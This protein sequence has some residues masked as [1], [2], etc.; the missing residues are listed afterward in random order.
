VASTS[1]CQKPNA[2]LETIIALLTP[3]F[4]TGTTD[5]FDA[6]SAVIETLAAYATRTRGELLRAAQIIAL[7]MTTLDVLAEAKT[8]EMSQS[9]R[10]RY[11]GCANSLNRCASNTE[12]ALERRLACD[13]PSTAEPMPEPASD[14]TTGANANSPVGQSATA[15][16]PHRNPAWPQERDRHLWA[17]AM[18]QT[19]Q[20]LGVP[21]QITRP[22][23]EAR[24]KP[25]G[26]S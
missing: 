20:Q 14:V 7:G 25:G 17:G 26:L 16:E 22:E 4:A 19:L 3:H 15:F 13:A 6:R 1:T 24:I 23:D 8:A 11:R 10:L 9:M 21:V 5:A 2:F 12:K 18:M